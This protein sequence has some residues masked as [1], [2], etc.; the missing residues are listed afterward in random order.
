MPKWVDVLFLIRNRIVGLFGLKADKNSP[1]M[2]TFFLLIKN[3]DEE[4][5]MCVDD[6]CLNFRASVVRNK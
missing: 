1:Q 5:M 3:R 2:G 6:K 4:T